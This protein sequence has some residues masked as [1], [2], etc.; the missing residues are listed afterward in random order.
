MPSV[1]CVQEIVVLLLVLAG[2]VQSSKYRLN[3]VD[4]TP[5]A[6]KRK[7]DCPSGQCVD[8]TCVVSFGEWAVFSTADAPFGYT[9]FTPR[10]VGGPATIKYVSED[11]TLKPVK[12]SRY[13][14]ITIYH[15]SDP[16]ALNELC[17]APSEIRK[18]AANP[19][20]VTRAVFNFQSKSMTETNVI[21]IPEVS[22]PVLE[23]GPV[24]VLFR[25]CPDDSLYNGE[26]SSGSGWT[27]F[28]GINSPLD[29]RWL[30]ST[31]LE[32]R[33]PYGYLSAHLYGMIPF[34]GAYIGFLSILILVLL[35]L[36][37]RY[38]RE[39]I[40][41]HY[42]I[43]ALVGLTLIGAILY[44]FT[45]TQANENGTAMCYPSCHVNY[46]A[47]MVVDE[48]KNTLA[49]VLVLVVCLGLGVV[50]PTLTTNVKVKISAVHFAYFSFSLNEN[51]RTMT[52]LSDTGSSAGEE[53]WASLVP[54]FLNV[55]ILCWIYIALNRTMANLV[56]QGETYKHKMF[57]KLTTLLSC[58]VLLWSVST[59]VLFL[60]RIE[61]IKWPWQSEWVWF[62]IWHFIF[63]IALAGIAWTWGPSG[64]SARLAHQQ[65][66]GMDDDDDEDIE[67]DLE[68]VD[69]ESID[70][71]D[72]PPASPANAKSTQPISFADQDK[73]EFEK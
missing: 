73:V 72:T 4:L 43:I 25:I 33:N 54:V 39:I 18:N 37:L 2:L 29:G 22:L 70:F 6:C 56:V 7:E 48:L 19:E 53:L 12:F 1:L 49:R 20:V 45:F 13:A 44:F 16:P 42:G 24:R 61:I 23:S 50:T 10:V 67:V 8:G 17:D 32:F 58:L 69:V 3:N 65:Q 62:A 38:R 35:G 41:I 11:G 15:D 68:M 66:L 30:M 40:H 14:A 47:S 21:Q 59:I 34:F 5:R 55:F 57:Q 36:M 52:S 64:T 71:Q 60:A 31:S 51:F 9:K 27:N 28:T 63:F 26:Q 46:L